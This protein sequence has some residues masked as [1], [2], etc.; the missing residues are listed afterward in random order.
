ML[1]H[2]KTP[3]LELLETPVMMSKNHQTKLPCLQSGK[4]ATEKSL[5]LLVNLVEIAREVRIF[6]GPWEL[7]VN[8]GHK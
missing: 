6:L 5:Q 2:L 7:A 1:A 8:S 4:G 3:F